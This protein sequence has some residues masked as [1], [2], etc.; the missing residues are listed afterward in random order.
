MGL[1]QPAFLCWG[2]G[3]GR[4]EGESNYTGKWNLGGRSSRLAAVGTRT[5]R[6]DGR[7]CLVWIP[8]TGP[9]LGTPEPTTT[10]GLVPCLF[11]LGLSV[12]LIVICAPVETSSHDSSFLMAISVESITYLRVL[13]NHYLLLHTASQQS[14][15]IVL[16]DPSVCQLPQFIR[17]REAPYHAVAFNVCYYSCK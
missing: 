1:G 3:Q 5:R 2:Q 9:E 13:R 6:S 15:R 4:G 16:F 10:Q 11:I 17:M 8:R 14:S 12:R 7:R